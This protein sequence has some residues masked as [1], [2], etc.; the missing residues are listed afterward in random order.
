VLG[1]E[2]RPVVHAYCAMGLEHQH[3]QQQVVLARCTSYVAA[4]V[5]VHACMTL[6]PKTLTRYILGDCAADC[7]L[8]WNTGC[9]ATELEYKVLRKEWKTFGYERWMEAATQAYQAGTRWELFDEIGIS[10]KLR[11]LRDSTWEHTMSDEP[12]VVFSHATWPLRVRPTE[13][14]LPPTES[15]PCRGHLHLSG[16]DHILEKAWMQWRKPTLIVNLVDCR[17]DYL[18]DNYVEAIRAFQRRGKY[19]CMNLAWSNSKQMRRITLSSTAA[20]GRIEAPLEYQHCSRCITK[21]HMRPP[22][23]HYAP[24]LHTMVNGR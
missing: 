20:M 1:E 7:S 8:L 18:A 24:R 16:V 23:M 2:Q 10:A 6:F 3:E 19:H 22:C 13:N 4:A 12:V 21:C 5:W 15:R 11:T 14:F 17:R 9:A